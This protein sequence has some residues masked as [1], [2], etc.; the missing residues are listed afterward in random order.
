MKKFKDLSGK[1]FG[2]LTVVKPTG[3]VRNNYIEYL[4]RCACGGQIRTTSK[5]L[6]SGQTRSCGC[7]RV[8]TAQD[9][10][11]FCAAAKFADIKDE[12]FGRWKVLECAGKKGKK[13]QR[14]HYYWVCRCDCGTVALVNGAELRR[15]GSKSCGCLK[16]QLSSKRLKKK[17]IWKLSQ[18]KR[19]AA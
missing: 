5:L 2:L 11:G 15:G 9:H 7:L 13:G 19:S 10:V 14:Q 1:R 12:R 8:R 4:C 3:E 18:Q 6:R 16:D 17:P